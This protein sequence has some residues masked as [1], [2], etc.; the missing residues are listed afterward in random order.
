MQVIC[1]VLSILSALI[2]NFWTA[3]FWLAFVGATLTAT[4]VTWLLTMTHFGW[5]DEVFLKNLAMTLGITAI[6]AALVSG[7]R[8]FARLK[9]AR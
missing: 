9:P 5:M 6:P 8:K 4:F 1:L 7:V 2:W 3:R